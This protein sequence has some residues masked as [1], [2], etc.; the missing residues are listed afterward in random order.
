MKKNPN[1]AIYYLY[2]YN[3]YTTDFP[4]SNITTIMTYIDDT[5]ILASNKYS[6]RAV[7]GTQLR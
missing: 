4:I 3:I 2:T 6:I 1:K 5:V 7:H